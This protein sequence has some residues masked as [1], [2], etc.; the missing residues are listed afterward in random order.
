SPSRAAMH[1]IEMAVI[2]KQLQVA[3]D[4]FVGDAEDIGKLANA[5][6]TGRAQALHDLIVTANC[7]RT[8]HANSGV[9]IRQSG[10][11]P[12]AMTSPQRG[13]R[14]DVSRAET[15]SLLPRVAF[16]QA[17]VIVKHGLQQHLRACR[18]LL[19]G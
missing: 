13:P 17:P 18:A 6:R 10:G 11:K 7:E 1:D 5:D 12:P 4:G 2:G 3:A 15:E 8:N 14:T 9:Q 16:G 19:L